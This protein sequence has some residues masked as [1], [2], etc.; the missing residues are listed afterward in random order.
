M[1]INILRW[2]KKSGEP[3][4]HTCIARSRSALEP[5]IPLS[6][7][8]ISLYYS[9]RS[10]TARKGYGAKRS[11]VIDKR[12]DVRIRQREKKNNNWH[13]TPCRYV[14]WKSDGRALVESS[15]SANEK[16]GVSIVFGLSTTIFRF[17]TVIFYI[18]LFFCTIF[19]PRKSIRRMFC[20]SSF[21]PQTIKT[22]IFIEYGRIHIHF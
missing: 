15:W 17:Q 20:S 21:P 8:H 19:Y 6:E 5:A 22:D 14:R 13:R 7:N 12:K 2:Y 11:P 9:M 18:I 1:D 4:S 3:T 10:N 16:R